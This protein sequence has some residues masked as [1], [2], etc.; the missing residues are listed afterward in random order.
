MSSNAAQ[1]SSVLGESW[2]VPDLPPGQT[3]DDGDAE[4]VHNKGSSEPRSYRSDGKSPSESQIT[5][6]SST[7]GPELIMPSISIDMTSDGS[8]VVPR[9]RSKQISPRDQGM[10]SSASQRD[11]GC[12]TDRHKTPADTPAPAASGMEFVLHKI[13]Y[14]A[15]RLGQS[16]VVWMAVNTILLI[17]MLHLLILPEL[18]Y[19]FPQL[20]QL[21]SASTLY[22]KTCVVHNGTSPKL[23][24]LPASYQHAVK[25][26][27][28]LQDFLNQT[29]Q[30]LTPLDNP[31]KLSDREFRQIYNT[32]R[33]T[34]PGARH[35]LDLEFEGA[36]TALR[37]ASRELDTLRVGLKSISDNLVSQEAR[38]SRDAQNHPG[39]L[40]GKSSNDESFW[41][42][43]L[44]YGSSQR[45]SEKGTLL[46]SQLSRL[47]QFLD[48]AVSRLSS[49]T[50]SLLTHLATLDDHLESIQQ[51]IMREEERE[52]GSSSDARNAIAAFLEP[53]W[54]ALSER[55]SFLP[56]NVLVSRSHD[57]SSNAALSGQLRR[58][59]AHHHPM[60]SIIG[61]LDKELKALQ[62]IRAMRV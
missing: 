3:R 26:R 2:V 28:Q 7:S 51:V 44:S 18:L 11:Q 25:T 9:R 13:S 33:D 45:G 47:E 62:K 58:I 4:C 36:W 53:M 55:F 30:A 59:S 40:Q 19:Q 21:P 41:G 37:S 38:R 32:I 1:N 6:T 10:A 20:C 56:S 60:A 42:R 57:N 52:H 50:D 27:I 61:K 24:G 14:L 22:P 48:T 15:Q 35:E 49:E 34:Y 54:S 46:A 12:A 39:L 8:W 43:F 5:S 29:V 16:K 23:A 17:P 31:L